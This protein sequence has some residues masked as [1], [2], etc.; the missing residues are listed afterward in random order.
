MDKD[1]LEP[2]ANELPT[3]S[4]GITP[5]AR[6]RSTSV[7]TDAPS[8]PRLLRPVRARD[9]AQVLHSEVLHILAQIQLRRTEREAIYPARR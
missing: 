1:S 8:L 2:G 5:D 4:L 7:I 6:S 9:S 3:Y